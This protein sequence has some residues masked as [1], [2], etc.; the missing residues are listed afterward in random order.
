MRHRG[1]CCGSWRAAPRAGDQPADDAR[2]PLRRCRPRAPGASPIALS[3]AEGVVT[4]RAIKA[5]PRRGTAAR[6]A[7]PPK[8]KDG[9]ER[10]PLADARIR[11][12]LERYVEAADAELTEVAD[13]L[14]EL[15]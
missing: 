7:R 4:K 5:R 12:L 15:N 9:E 8:V 6:K 1:C 3:Q 10:E 14:F 13:G 11:P 2:R